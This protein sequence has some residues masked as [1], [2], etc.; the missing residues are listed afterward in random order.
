M[1]D[2]DADLWQ[3]LVSIEQRAVTLRAALSRSGDRLDILASALSENSGA[4]QQYTALSFLTAFP[5]EAPNFIPQLF[6]EALGGKWE[7]KARTIL[8][9]APRDKV[10]PEVLRLAAAHLPQPEV[11]DYLQVAALLASLS[12]SDA[13]A[14]V[15]ADALDSTDE[16]IREAGTFIRQHYA[17]VIAQ[18][19]R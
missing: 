18:G 7:H 9:A 12:A 17:A 14:Q 1:T 5:L 3:A 11:D 16:E 2:G 13:L 4:W 19:P 15:A 8:A 10:L 6:H